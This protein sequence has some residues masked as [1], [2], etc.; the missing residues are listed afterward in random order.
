MAFNSLPAGK[1]QLLLSTDNL[2][3][4]FGPKSEPGLTLLNFFFEKVDFE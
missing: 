4:Q 1:S 2:C 3:K